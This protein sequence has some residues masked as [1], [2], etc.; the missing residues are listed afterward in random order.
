MVEASY[1]TQDVKQL[2]GLNELQKCEFDLYKTLSWRL[3]LATPIE[4]AK[5]ILL[6]ANSDFDFNPIL[7]NVNSYILVC[8]IGK[9]IL[10]YI[11][12]DAEIS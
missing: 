10:I 2:R 5:I 9:V 4:L 1:I 11:F 3:N 12:L 7:A 6:Y 8:L